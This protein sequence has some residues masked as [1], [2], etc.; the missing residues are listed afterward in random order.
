MNSVHHR[1]PSS[2]TAPPSPQWVSAI[3]QQLGKKMCVRSRVQL[4]VISP[5]SLTMRVSW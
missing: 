4:P 2:A 5:S 3:A 1:S